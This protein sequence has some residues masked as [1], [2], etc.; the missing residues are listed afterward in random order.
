MILGIVTQI[1]SR[2][3]KPL[4]IDNIKIPLTCL[5]TMSGGDSKSYT[6]NQ[7]P[8]ATSRAPAPTRAIDWLA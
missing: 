7:K 2:L 6:F 5:S 1:L 4:L 3:A 8:V